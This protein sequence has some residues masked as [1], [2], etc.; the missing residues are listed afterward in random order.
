MTNS[1]LIKQIDGCA[2]EIPISL[3]FP[4]IYICKMEDIVVK[5]LKLI[6]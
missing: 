2:M 6:I 1:G 5:T 3:A 4:E